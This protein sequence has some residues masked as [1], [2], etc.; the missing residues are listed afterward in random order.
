[1]KKLYF[2][3]VLGNNPR[4]CEVSLEEISDRTKA[5][6]ARKWICKYFIKE[7]YSS[8]NEKDLKN[9]INA[10]RKN[11]CRRDH[12]ILR[13]VDTKSGENKFICKVL[14]TFFVIREKTVYRIVYVNE[15]RIQVDG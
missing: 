4:K 5:K 3:N 10:E 8:E 6:V 7:K 11:N 1:M 15:L 9:W 12:H 2:R 13:R 14:G